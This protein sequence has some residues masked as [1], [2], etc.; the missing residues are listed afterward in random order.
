MDNRDQLLAR[1][2]RERSARRAA[3]A[4]QQQKHIE[5]SLAN[6]ALARVRDMLEHRVTERTRELQRL[7]DEYARKTNDLEVIN[8]FALGL[9]KQGSLDDI[10]WDIARNAV[11]RLGLEDCVIYLL[12][13]SRQFLVQRAA[14]GPKNPAREDIL[15][16][17]I[18][19]IG[20]G[21]VGT[22]AATGKPARVRD[23]RKSDAYIKDDAFRLSELAVPILHEGQ[24]IGVIDSED[25][26]PDYYTDD[27][28]ELFQTIASMAST[29]IAVA[30]EKQKLQAT[31]TDLER[32]QAD[33]EQATARAEQAS[34]HK[35]EFLAN[36][37]HEI[38]TPLNGVLGLN[39]LLAETQLTPE[40][41]D[42]VETIR[43]SGETLL[44]IINDILDFSKIEAGRLELESR[45]FDVRDCVRRSLGLIAPAARKKGLV[46]DC[47]LA[48]EVPEQIVGDV[49]RVSQILVNLLSNAV[50]FTEHGGISVTV[51]ATL[52]R[53][54]D[55]GA[56]YELAFAVEDT[57]IGIP[58]KRRQLL[59]QPFQQVDAS[60]TRR[61]GGT[62]LG[63]AICRRLAEMLGG[64]IW[65]EPRQGGGSIFRFTL[66]GRAAEALGPEAA[67]RR[68]I[69]GQMAA[70]HPLRILV[71]EDNVVNQKVTLGMLGRLGY[72]ADVAGNGH[73]AITAIA[74]REYDA[75]LMDV[76]MPQMDGLEAA[77]HVR[78]G[79][80]D[81]QPY[82]IAF[83]ADVLTGDEERFRAVGMNDYISKPIVIDR[84]AKALEACPSTLA[85]AEN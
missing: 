27:H 55:G 31:V 12:D 77:R 56:G 50:K 42:Y 84:L 74:E 76:Q 78:S 47:V 5:L 64:S 39:S 43:E 4:S 24:V 67:G 79:P 21:V 1:L 25:A 37:S 68:A 33:L 69:D 30:L 2:E 85:P 81:R 11:A 61:F 45:A 38:R 80:S 23:T 65:V 70:R 59:F 75:V 66:R 8:A 10:L 83:T 20:E 15:N 14:H 51:G 36:M 32:T 72:A 3:E 62:G 82:I 63:L 17:I 46:V 29:R 26:R 41:R 44:T 71:V 73:E 16:P 57:G 19:R 34:R 48:S 28:V 9:L 13:E 58:E 60:T 54:P 6:Q 53:L 35:S 40:Q 22:V 52:E 49:T 18:I 7:N